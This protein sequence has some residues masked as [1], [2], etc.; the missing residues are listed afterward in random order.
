MLRECDEGETT[1]TPIL[2]VL[3]FLPCLKSLVSLNTMGST[4]NILCS[5]ARADAT[6]F[7]FVIIIVA[8]RCCLEECPVAIGTRT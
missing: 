1:E 4:E 7:K 2:R 3:Q 6:N 8:M 5:N